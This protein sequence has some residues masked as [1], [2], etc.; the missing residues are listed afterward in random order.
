MIE[1]EFK[2]FPKIPRLNREVIITEKIDGTNACV[3]V[4]ED[5]SVF[6][7]SRS[8]IIVPGND[9]F[10]FATWVAQNEPE[11]RKLGPGY[12][13]GEWWGVGI[14]RGYALSE[15]RFSLFNIHKWGDP[16]TR[17]E[18]CD[19]VPLLASGLLSSGVVD[20]ALADLRRD[21]SRAAPGYTNPEGVVIFHTAGGHLFKV[22]LENDEGYKGE[23]K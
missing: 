14:Q 18:C 4:G 13:Y 16:L 15:R 3:V 17:P 22:L 5:L 9:N 1:R 2:A 19:V 20:R 12:H 6:A 10:G 11:L 21:G 7:Q 23:Q 8:R